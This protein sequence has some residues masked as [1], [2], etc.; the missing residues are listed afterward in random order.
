MENTEIDDQ[1]F[2]VF[3]IVINKINLSADIFKH[4]YIDGFRHCLLQTWIS[5]HI[6]KNWLYL[7][8]AG[9]LMVPLQRLPSLLVTIYCFSLG[10]PPL[11]YSQFLWLEWDNPTHPPTAGVE[12]CPRPGLWQGPSLGYSEVSI[13]QWTY[14]LKDGNYWRH[15]VFCCNWRNCFFHRDCWAGWVSP[16]A[17]GS[18]YFFSTVP[19]RLKLMKK[20]S[21]GR[22]HRMI[23]LD[24]TYRKV[25]KSLGESL[26]RNKLFTLS[27]NWLFQVI[28]QS[29]REIY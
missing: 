21:W 11:L 9:I 22:H 3:H 7:R 29:Q 4:F 15:P 6:R 1:E 19:L 26:R 28:Y 18:P 24:N 25:I 27:Q 20:H 2:A 13:Q 10:E 23:F 8:A 17:T 14:D 12:A 16:R 5:K